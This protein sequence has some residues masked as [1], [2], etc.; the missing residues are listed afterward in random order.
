VPCRPECTNTRKKSGI[1]TNS[2]GL[3]RRDQPEYGAAVSPAHEFDDRYFA[4]LD[5]IRDHWWVRGMQG[6]GAALLGRPTAGLRVLD[7]GVGSGALLPWAHDLAGQRPVTAVDL[8]APAVD[9]CRALGLGTQLARASSARLPFRAA[10]FDLVLSSDVL[11]HLPLGDDV[12]AVR[13][14]ARVLAP[15]G[16]A[17]VR[18]NSAHGRGHVE[19]HDDW[20]LYRPATLR[21]LFEAAGLVVDALTPVNLV[22]G[23][24]ATA[25]RPFARHDHHA[26]ATDDLADEHRA[27][28]G[29][30]I[31]EPVHPLKNRALL[32]LLRV[33]AW[34]VAR[35]GRRLPFGHSLYAVAR[36]P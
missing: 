34:Y 28:H 17:L 10:S 12:R 29:L 6:I 5:A 19:Q 9:Q 30:G 18:T 7:A 15:G 8:A 13:E 24:W 1:G 27:T 2:Q 14:F 11:Q 32:Q 16:R 4:R 31:P 22:Q 25:T 26:C 35:P 23:L 33:E 3:H 21:A 36:K 20:R